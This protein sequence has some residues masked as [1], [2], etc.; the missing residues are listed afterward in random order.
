MQ[1]KKYK[2]LERKSRI[3]YE[4]QIVNLSQTALILDDQTTN[5][6]QLSKIVLDEKQKLD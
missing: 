6:E 2:N 5:E 3:G 1:K 4:K